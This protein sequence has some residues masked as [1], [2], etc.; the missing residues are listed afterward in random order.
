MKI[1]ICSIR[2]AMLFGLWG[3]LMLAGGAQRPALMTT[4]FAVGE[5]G[6]T[7]ILCSLI[8]R[9]Y[10]RRAMTDSMMAAI[11]GYTVSHLGILAFM[12]FGLAGSSAADAYAR[13]TFLW[14]ELTLRVGLVV[15]LASGACVLMKPVIRKFSLRLV[16]QLRQRRFVTP[17]TDYVI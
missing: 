8:L 13:G 11:A 6:A 4:L 7:G 5:L 2:N 17:A 16:R 15:V 3:A 1:A 14:I 12:V 9:Q 10:R